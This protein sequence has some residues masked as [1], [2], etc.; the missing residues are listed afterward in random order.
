M[1]KDS[2]GQSYLLWMMSEKLSAAELPDALEF[3]VNQ[4]IHQ[5]TVAGIN[6]FKAREDT[7][8]KYHG[9]SAIG[10]GLRDALA[11]AFE[12]TRNG[13]QIVEYDTWVRTE[14]TAV[15][16]SRNGPAPTVAAMHSGVETLAFRTDIP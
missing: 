5:R 7:I 10:G 2:G 12:F 16:F 4:K 15:F 6:D 11:V 14:K 1:V 8:Y 13:A 3:S 9:G